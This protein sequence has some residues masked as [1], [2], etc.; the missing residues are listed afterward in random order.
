MVGLNDI[1]QQIFSLIVFH[2]QSLDG[3]KNKDLLHS[4]V[5]GGPGVGKTKFISILVK[6][7][8]I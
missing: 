3:K 5:Y 6:S 4:V 8:R 7:L 2:L 1:K